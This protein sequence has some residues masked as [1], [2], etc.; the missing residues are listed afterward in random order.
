MAVLAMV[1]SVFTCISKT[2]LLIV[3]K[4]AVESGHLTL[5]FLLQPSQFTSLNHKKTFKIV[6]I[7]AIHPLPSL[8]S[9]P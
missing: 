1:G 3:I 4:V 5:N 9:L 7:I 2:R 6:R 8:P